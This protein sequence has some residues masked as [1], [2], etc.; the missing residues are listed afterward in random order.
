MLSQMTR[1]IL[2]GLV[3]LKEFPDASIMQIES[4]IFELT[5][6]RVLRIFP[7][8]RVDQARQTSQRFVIKAQHLANFARSRSP[9][10][11]NHVRSHR[12]A[13]FSITFIDILNR[14]LALIAAGQ[15]KIDVRPFA[16]LFRKKTFEQEFHA[17]RIDC[18]NAQAVTDRAVRRRATTLN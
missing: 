17:D 10:I 12:G 6:G 2:H 14:A 4:R 8:P 13:Q 7:L 11:S 1:Q 9:T 3:K 5:C 16:A 18:G 15:I